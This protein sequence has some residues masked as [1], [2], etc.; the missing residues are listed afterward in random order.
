MAWHV[1]CFFLNRDRIHSFD[2][3]KT[4]ILRAFGL[5]KFSIVVIEPKGYTHARGWDEL[6]E[7]LL[8]GFQGAGI[9]CCYKVNSFER[10]RV[11]IIIGAYLLDPE[12]EPFVPKDSIF[13][14]TEQIAQH[15]EIFDHRHIMNIR[16]W[17][18]KHFRFIDYNQFNIATLEKWGASEVQV[19]KL[20]FS[21]SLHRIKKEK[22]KYDCIFYGGLTPR[23]KEISDRIIDSGINLKWLYGIFG[24]ERDSFISKSRFALNMHLYESQ[25]FE[26]VRVNYLIHNKI[27]VLGEVNN[28]TIIDP[29]LKNVICA[30]PK[31][32]LPDLANELKDNPTYC[33]ELAERAFGWLENQS[34]ADIL[35]ELFT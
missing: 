20:G 29:G 24:E 32:L 3:S 31:E 16:F 13:F 21:P 2:K 7:L 12:N 1:F 4:K 27:A 6:V 14:N 22:S 5:A 15:S 26:V 33:D 35:R 19:L 30:G 11:N 28:K 9:D 17:A 34:Q 10:S 25:I 18:Q 8:W 23:R